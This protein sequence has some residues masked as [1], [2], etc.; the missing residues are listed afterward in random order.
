MVTGRAAEF[1]AWRFGLGGH[2]ATLVDSR[3]P[4]CP[5]RIGWNRTTDELVPPILGLL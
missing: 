3:D 5:R 1:E 4:V 2:I